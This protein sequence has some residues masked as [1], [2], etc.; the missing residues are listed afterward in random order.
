MPLQNRV[1]PD[2]EIVAI[3]A[4][5]TMLGNRGGRIHRP[6][7][8]LG[9]RRWASRAWIACELQFRGRQRQVMAPNS[10]TELFF[11]DEATALSAGHRPCFECRRAAA[12]Q[13]ATL[14]AEACDGKAET[15]TCRVGARARAGDMDRVLQVERVANDGSKRTHRMPMK[16][17]PDGAMILLPADGTA[18]EGEGMTPALVL[19]QH[20]LLWSPDGYA[21]ARPRPPAQAVHV[22]TPESII[23]VLGAGYE[24]KLHE[25]ALTFT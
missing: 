10:Y 18:G 15:G 22:L 4:R 24:P 20:L 12:N 13:F 8:T 14:W 9:N 25:T 21:A 19:G 6:D 3:T 7:Q 17:L 1:R 11:L 16:R 2:G 5:G 23:A